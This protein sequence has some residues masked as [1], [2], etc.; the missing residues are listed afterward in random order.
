[1][2]G[3]WQ[4]GM[5][6]KR[7]CAKG[8]GIKTEKQIIYS[9]STHPF[10]NHPLDLHRIQNVNNLGLAL[11]EHVAQTKRGA[12]TCRVSN[13][14]IYSARVEDIQHHSMLIPDHWRDHASHLKPG[15]KRALE[16]YIPLLEAVNSKEVEIQRLTDEEMVSRSS[17]L[18]KRVQ[19]SSEKVF[20]ILPEA[21]ALVREASLRVLGMR[22]YDVQI[23]GGIALSHGTV[24]EMR[25]GEG[26]TL[27]AIFPAYLYALEGKGAHIVTVN[28]YLAQRD[29]EWVGKVLRFLGL[30]VGVVTSQT[31]QHLRSMELAADVTYLTA[32][33]LAFMYLQDNSAPPMFPVALNRPLYFAVVDEVDSILIDEAR[34]PFIVNIPGTE[35]TNEQEWIIAAKIAMRLEGPP[36]PENMSPD[37][38]VNY[39]EGIPMQEYMKVDFIPDYRTKGANITAIGM[40]KTVQL[41]SEPPIRRVFMLH[42]ISGDS[43]ENEDQITHVLLLNVKDS[44][45][46]QGMSN[47]SFKGEIVIRKVGNDIDQTTASQ[48]NNPIDQVIEMD[49]FSLASILSVLKK[50]GYCVIPNE[51]VAEDAWDKVIP[52][53]LWSGRQNA[54]GRYVNQALRACHA[55]QKNVDYIVRDGEVVVIDI[56][57]GRER[58][59]SRWQSGLHQALEAKEMILQSDD[60][61]SIRPEDFDQGRVTYQVLFSEYQ[62]LSGMTGTA[63]TEA[64]EFEE[65]YGLPV[66]RIPPHRPSR[67]TDSSL[68]VYSRREYWSRKLQEDVR[69]AVLQDRPVLIGTMSVEASELVQEIIVETPLDPKIQEHEI[70]ALSAWVLDLPH[71]LPPHPQSNFSKQTSQ[72]EVRAAIIF[73]ETL[74]KEYQVFMSNLQNLLNKRQVM[75][76]EQIENAIYILGDVCTTRVWSLKNESQL[77][78]VNHMINLFSTIINRSSLGQQKRVNI[79]NARPERARKEAEI[80]A[81]AG[82]PGTVTVATSMAGRGTDILLG[83]N[84]KGLTLLTVEYFVFRELSGYET[85]VEDF[86]LTLS[87][88][89]EAW[90]DYTDKK[91]ATYLPETLYRAITDLKNS[92]DCSELRTVSED[93]LRKSF[94]SIIERSESFL[95][96]FQTKVKHEGIKA[97]SMEEKLQNL[98]K[99]VDHTIDEDGIFLARGRPDEIP[100]CL[101]QATYWCILKFAA[102]QWIWLENECNNLSMRGKIPSFLIDPIIRSVIRNQE[103]LQQGARDVARKYDAVIDPYRRHIYRLRR[104]LTRGGDAARCSLVHNNLREL[105][106]DLV[107]YHCS[108]DASRSDWDIPSLLSDIMDLL[109]NSIIDGKLGKPDSRAALMFSSEED[110]SLALKLIDNFLAVAIEE[111][112]HD[113]I[114]TPLANAIQDCIGSN[115]LRSNR[116]PSIKFQNKDLAVSP[117]RHRAIMTSR[118]AAILSLASKTNSV[119]SRLIIWTGDLLSA[120]YEAKRC[121]MEEA[122]T[123]SQLTLKSLNMYQANSLV[124]VWER[125]IALECID[126]LWSDFL[127]DITVLQAAC[128]SRAFSLFDPVDEFHLETATAFTRLLNQYSRE[129]SAR[130]LGPIDMV[131]IRWLEKASDVKNI[132]ADI[133]FLRKLSK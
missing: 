43:S 35:R 129:V 108:I 38:L 74:R 97:M 79:L 11:H 130:I 82:L 23:L 117:V 132:D 107:N 14:S 27:V 1:M 101:T 80:I 22:P 39:F 64:E 90:S 47:T 95:S 81:Q 51:S 28:D 9:T 109:S 69:E 113:D 110:A 99:Y 112:S 71:Q 6:H 37:D 16:E 58:Q 123:C 131:H 96:H 66:V 102:M 120:L 121:L 46:S 116:F 93:D 127:Q 40:R 8:V 100:S 53:V 36:V 15:E 119:H 25:T 91:L 54:W 68:N 73:Y 10:S 18:A 85:V 78:S 30:D 89:N 57:T 29:A 125:D 70:M 75:Q 17:F 12:T 19:S 114:R 86:K 20:D 84:P 104:T 128:Q 72:A 55:F 42:E 122:L 98:E 77:Q 26:K 31:P 32:Y 60:N 94:E 59:R 4:G 83:G 13:R 52:A 103:Q 133:D 48:E 65:A 33:E 124:R 7:V 76:L 126:L 45:T 34:N 50:S 5:L 111:M 49:D 21:F 115:L 44:T 105:A 24:A 61:I 106:S 118:D 62:A 87:Q 67:R 63:A 3:F 41:L 56:A 88:I 92:L 2:T